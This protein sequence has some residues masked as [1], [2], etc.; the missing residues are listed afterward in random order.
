MRVSANRGLFFTII[1]A[2]LILIGSYFAIQYAKGNYHFTES[3]FSETAG[4]LAVNSFP[5]GAKVYIDGKLT[6]ATDD[7]LYLNPG[8]YQVEIKKD[9]Y[10]GWHKK[11]EIEKNLVTQANARLFPS[12]P[13]LTPLTFIGV[14]NLSPSP[15]GQKIVYFTASNSS[16]EKNGL[17]LIELAANPLSLQKGAKQITDNPPAFNLK[18]AQFIWSPD[19][20]QLIILTKNKK[21]LIDVNKKSQLN[22]LK[23]LSLKEF[24]QLLDSWENEMYLKEKQF[25]NKFPPTI[26]AIATRSAYNVYFS[27]DKKK[28]LYTASSAATIPPDLLPPLP[29]ASTQPQE[30][31]L[32]PGNIYVY[33]REEDRNFKV[34][35][36]APN[37]HQLKKHLLTI[38]P[39]LK[40]GLLAT[41][42]MSAHL[43]L[44]A[45]SA[46]ETA[47]NWRVYHSPLYA[48]TF[49]WYPD[50][51]HL[52][53][54]ENNTIKIEE[55]DGTNVQNLYA[56]PF[57]NRFIY[58]W[59][60]GS[61]ILIYT[62]FSPT[63]PLNLY[64]I[65][66]K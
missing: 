58:P 45:S 31:K 13:S 40:L 56:G 35:R 60:D 54:G 17:W 30:R 6:T 32:H 21:L 62:S 16:Q 53:F 3:G 8:T 27:P 44:Q 42:T 49:Q 2:L 38:Q 41:A 18:K 34:G 63:T 19:S 23:S 47:A 26:I 7:T 46:A 57:M 33:D 59:P 39:N 14:E 5:D 9:G 50:S 1:S 11:L 22:Q 29:A 37:S 65:E 10:S 15:D 61:R 24:H 51:N 66:L 52:F 48:N 25:L 55:Y 28:L 64:A 4:L 43:S 36:E 12:A 20:D